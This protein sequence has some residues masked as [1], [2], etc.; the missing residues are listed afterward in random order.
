M[1]LILTGPVHS[2]KT[3]RLRRLVSEWRARGIALDGFL[4]P[5]VFRAGKRTGYDWLDL[6]TNCP[7]PFLRLRG[8]ADWEKVG[9][10][11]LIPSTLEKAKRKIRT[12]DLG[13]L[14][15]IDEIGPLEL[16]GGGV[17]PELEGVLK[18]PL[19]CCLVVVRDEILD[20]FGRVAPVQ[21]KMIFKIEGSAFPSDLTRAIQSFQGSAEDISAA[22]RPD[23]LEGGTK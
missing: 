20:R 21:P 7:A 23:R 4:S 12:H 16:R 6:E 3:T 15:I 9:P 18:A 13:K 17:W 1:L 10:Y 2:G 19:F 14:L 8:E 11:F 22:S 5:A